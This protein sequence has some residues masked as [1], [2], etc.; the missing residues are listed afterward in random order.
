LILSRTIVRGID[1]LEAGT[2]AVAG[3][4]LSYTVVVRDGDELVNLAGAFNHM[5]GDLRAQHA[6]IEQRGEELRQ[7]MEAQSRLFA[8]VRQLSTPILP[9][10]DGVILLPLVGHIDTRRAQDIIAVL[11]QGVATER[12][13]VAILDI[14]GA[15]GL[16]TQVLG[17]LIGAMRGVELLGARPLL[18]GISAEVAQIIAAHDIDLG[19]LR[20][21]RDLRDA[22]RGAL[23]EP[24]RNAGAIRS[25][26][27]I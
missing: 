8:T 22:M 12:A 9:V 14:T 5:T 17:L 18:A 19:D 16:D 2:A 3:G 15:A 21:Y 1:A 26:R 11:L 25:G 10:A 20:S 23:A 7:S 13:R 24:L 4:D 27:T 6:A